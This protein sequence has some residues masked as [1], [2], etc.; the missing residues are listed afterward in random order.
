MNPCIC[1]LLVSDRH[2]DVLYPSPAPL[3]RDHLGLSQRKLAMQATREILPR[4]VTPKARPLL[5]APKA[6]DGWL[7]RWLGWR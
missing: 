7:A 1:R 3:M 5:P 4:D 2:G 6:P